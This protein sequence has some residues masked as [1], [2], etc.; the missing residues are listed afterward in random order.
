MTNEQIENEIKTPGTYTVHADAEQVERALKCARGRYQINVIQGVESLSGATLTG[1]AA[2]YGGHY[3]VSR[4]NLLD[5]MTA[6]GV[7]WS[8][9]RGPNNRRV[10]VIGA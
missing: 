9:R 2:L 10:L 6:A 5:R 4:T 7:V 3:A 8:E 1:T